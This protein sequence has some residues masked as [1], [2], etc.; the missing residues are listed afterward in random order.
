MSRSPTPSAIHELTGAYK[1]DPQ[2]RRKA[3]PKPKGGIGPYPVD[4]VKT[5]EEVWDY[6][7]G[8]MAPN[9][10]T[11]MD[12]SSF[13]IAVKLFTKMLKDEVNCTELGQLISLLGKFGLNPTDRTKIGVAAKDDKP[14]E[15]QD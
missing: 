3:E 13:L 10:L 7:V 15:W 1:K 14:S 2:R 9:V 6:L 8:T 5:E 4:M 12:R 11:D